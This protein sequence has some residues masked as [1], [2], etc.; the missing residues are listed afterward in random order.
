MLTALKIETCEIT[1]W[2]DSMNV[3]WWIHV[4]MKAG[5]A[6]KPFVANIIGETQCH[7][8]PQQWRFVPNDKN[9][10]DR[11]TGGSSL[12]ELATIKDT[13]WEGPWYLMR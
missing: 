8:S 10:A 13:W 5:R 12:E 2:A 11:L 4:P 1:F 3:L 6:F 7:A 9:P